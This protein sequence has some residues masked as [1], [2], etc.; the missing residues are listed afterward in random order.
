MEYVV[1]VLFGWLPKTPRLNSRLKFT[2][3]DTRILNMRQFK[4]FYGYCFQII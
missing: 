3:S 2:D 4:I 1:G